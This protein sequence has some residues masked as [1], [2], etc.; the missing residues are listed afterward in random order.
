MSFRNW[1]KEIRLKP[2]TYLNFAE[3]KLS[4]NY[5]AIQKN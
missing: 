2:Q 1:K 3:V 4:K 5:I